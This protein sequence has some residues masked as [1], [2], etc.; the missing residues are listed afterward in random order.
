[1]LMTTLLITALA[2]TTYGW[3]REAFARYLRTKYRE[4]SHKATFLEGYLLRLLF[5]D[6]FVARLMKGGE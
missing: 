4:G 6:K 1:M 5:P 3:A 2:A